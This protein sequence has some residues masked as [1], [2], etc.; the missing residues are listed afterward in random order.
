[1]WQ[2]SYTKTFDN[3]QKQ[4]IWQ[5]WSDIDYWHEWDTDIESA[6]LA[7]PFAVGSKFKLKPKAGPAVNITL[8]EV[9]KERKFTDCTKFPGAKMYGSHTM[10]E[11]GDRL[12][13]NVTM[14]MK[15]PLGF[16]WRKLVAEKI[17]AKLPEQMDALVRLARSKA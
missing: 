8:V 15:G 4:A 17:V 6:K 5:L 10:E 9:E 7:G 3:V 13:L 2:K 14:T 1:M 16:L 12:H 11:K